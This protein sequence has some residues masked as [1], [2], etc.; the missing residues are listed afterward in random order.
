V[1][2]ISTEQQNYL[3][4]ILADQTAQSEVKLVPERGGIV[5]QWRFKTLNLLYLDMERFSHP[6]L[7]VRGGIP[8]LFPICGN[9]PGNTY[10]VNDH[11]YSLK[12][13]G[14]ARDLAWQVVDRDTTEMARLTLRLY[15]SEQTLA[16]YPFEFTLLFTYEV[17]GDTLMIRQTVINRSTNPMPFSLGLHPYFEVP[18]KAQLQFEIPAPQYFDHLTQATLPFSGEFDFSQ[19]EIDVAFKGV[20]RQMATVRDLSRGTQMT[21]RYDHTYSTLVFWTQK[22]KNFYCLVPWTAPRNALNS[23]DHLLT[24]DP[25]ASLEQRVSLTVSLLP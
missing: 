12:Q 23:G 11:P 17:F 6:E 13:H 4:Y 8:I 1:F 19:P 25:G 2:S 15:S 18:D 3:T 16:A 22:E 5:T 21:I 20:T 7:S 24:L 10:T 9:L 14:F